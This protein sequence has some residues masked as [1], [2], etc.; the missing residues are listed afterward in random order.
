MIDITVLFLEGGNFSTAVIPIEVFRGAGVLWNRFNNLKVEPLFNVETASMGGRPARTDS[1][2]KV[3]PSGSIE[4]VRK[5]DI[6]FVP[7][8]GLD[9]DTLVQTPY[10]VDEAITRNLRVIPY[11]K[12]WAAR[13][14]TLAGVCSGV[15]ML[16]A[17]GLL[18]G[19]RAT[20]HWGLVDLYREK[21]P[22]VDWQPEHLVTEDRGIICGGGVNSA[23]DLS[24]YLVEKYCGREQA[25]Q[26]ARSLVIEMP[27]A[28][29]MPFASEKAKAQHDDEAIMGA[30]DWIHSN[31]SQPVQ[32]ESLAK[33]VG[34]SSRNFARR[35]KAATG[36]T[37]LAYL[38]GVRMGVAKRLLENGRQCVQDVATAVGYDDAIFFR[39]LFRRHAGITPNEYRQRFGPARLDQAAE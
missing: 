9:I 7:A 10:D 14:V 34:M 22:R 32:F 11:L 28:W 1:I 23:A 21:F 25:T 36:Q 16:A 24:L 15:G 26:I 12:K 31:Y 2:M 4:D 39:T 3:L 38:H 19:K 5:P 30:Q 8:A 17:A 27:R 6:V 20:T 37:P 35:F 13:G 29:Q 18:D 33:R